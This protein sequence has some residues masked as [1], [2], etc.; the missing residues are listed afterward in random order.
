[1][2][3]SLVSAGHL[4]GGG[5]DGIV[6]IFVKRHIKGLDRCRLS[7]TAALPYTN[8]TGTRRGKS[9]LERE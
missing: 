8:R 6:P 7:R 2:L 5:F 3:D 1:V 9:E 4:S